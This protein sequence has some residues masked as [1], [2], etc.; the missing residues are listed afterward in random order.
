V[1][2]VPEP[3]PDRI[4][5]GDIFQ[6]FP[7][8]FLPSTDFQFLRDDGQTYTEEELPGGWGQEEL[9]I[10]R[11]RRH[12]IILVSQTCDVHEEGK[13]NLHLAAEETY[14]YQL[15]HYCPVF[16]LTELQNHKSLRDA[17]KDRKHL[18]QNLPGG[19]FF[20]PAHPSGSFPDSIAYPH[21]VCAITKT[22]ANRFTSFTPKQ[23][24]ASLAPPFR[25]AFANKFG[26][27]YA[28]VALPTGA[29]ADIFKN[30]APQ[31]R[32]AAPGA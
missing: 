29:F 9:L 5:Q 12:R 20:L 19:A 30:N 3:D 21:W 8:F 24:L 32:G 10:V 31:A 1:Y 13:P 4:Y 27:V 17:V 28:R 15:I 23:R 26:Q 16:P 22:K 6:E 18:N 14:V 2:Y 25:E 7:C 11:A